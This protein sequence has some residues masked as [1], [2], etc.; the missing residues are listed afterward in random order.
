[1]EEAKLQ[2]NQYKQIRVQDIPVNTYIE[3]KLHKG[4]KV[5]EKEITMGSGET[6]TAYSTQVLHDGVE[7]Y[8]NLT[9]SVAQKFRACNLG[10]TLHIMAIASMLKG[11]KQYV[12]DVQVEKD[13]AGQPS[14]EEAA[15]FDKIITQMKS[16]NKTLLDVDNAII[17]DTFRVDFEMELDDAKALVPLFKKYYKSKNK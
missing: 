3:V 5:F 11:G 12:V 7:V 16:I 14:K 9:K 8:I 10:D 2:Q 15:M 6:F 17:I 13:P 4:S 1:M